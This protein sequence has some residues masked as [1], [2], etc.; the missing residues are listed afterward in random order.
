MEFIG[1]I[2]HSAYDG[3]VIFSFRKLD[4][5]KSKDSELDVFGWETIDILLEAW[6]KFKGKKVKITISKED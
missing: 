5:K 4:S 1:K 6:G 2:E 3:K